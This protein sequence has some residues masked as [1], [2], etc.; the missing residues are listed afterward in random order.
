MRP[1][2]SSTAAAASKKPPASKARQKKTPLE[3][4]DTT[5]QEIRATRKKRTMDEVSKDSQEDGA[6]P[7][8]PESPH[9]TKGRRGPGKRQRRSASPMPPPATKKRVPTNDHPGLIDKKTRRSKAEIAADKATKESEAAIAAAV[10][11][12]TLTRL[13]EIEMEQESVEKIRLEDIIRKRP[14]ASAAATNITDTAQGDDNPTGMNVDSGVEE[15]LSH[16]M[17]VDYSSDSNDDD[18]L[19]DG[20]DSTEKEATK[21]VKLP[22]F[23]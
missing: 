7:D 12:K 22:V 20:S 19:S 9:N 1:T 5:N 17:D 2:Q 10:E 11:E 6:S 3:D 18:D 15:D 14:A 23:D 8:G 21:K 4:N 16:L 13:A